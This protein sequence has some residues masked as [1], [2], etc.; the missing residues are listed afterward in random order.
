MLDRQPSSP[1]EPPKKGRG[2]STAMSAIA[3]IAEQKRI[4]K[5]MAGASAQPQALKKASVRKGVR[6]R[7]SMKTSSAKA[8]AKGKK[9]A[10]GKAKS[11]KTKAATGGKG[12]G[13]GNTSAQAFFFTY[14]IN[15]WIRVIN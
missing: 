4:A 11:K 1:M 9:K 6:R 13:K 14:N 15:F 5:A 10:K 8:K 12:K 7:I 3:D 2:Q